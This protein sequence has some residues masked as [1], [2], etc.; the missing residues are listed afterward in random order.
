M[1]KWLVIAGFLA[2]ALVATTVP[3]VKNAINVEPVTA[4]PAGVE[5]GIPSEEVRA[6]E[7]AAQA[8]CS[9]CSGGAAG[10]SDAGDRINSLKGY[11][12]EYYSK[13]LQDPD[14]TVEVQDLGCHQ[15]AQIL[16]NGEVI[17]KLSINGGQISEI[18]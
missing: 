11:I 6:P 9:C 1:R 10:A 17:K 12:Y 15:E 18:G 13:Q 14:I 3:A 4:N 5:T 8:G 2:L 7:A 16:K